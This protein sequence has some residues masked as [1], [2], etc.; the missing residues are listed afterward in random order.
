MNNV[1]TWMARDP[2][3]TTREEL[4]RLIDSNDQLALEERFSA[5]L[6]FGTAGLRGI[7]GAGPNRMNRLVIQETALGLGTY[8]LQQVDDAAAKGVVIGY[9][10][11]PDSKQFATDA[12]V[13]LGS[14]GIH[15]YLTETVAP[16]PVVAFS[17][18]HL[19]AA[20]GVVVTA[21]HNPPAYNGFKVYWGNGAQ[22]IPPH[23]SGIAAQID[24]AAQAPLPDLSLSQIEPLG[25]LS[26]LGGAFYA[27]YRHAV[28]SSPFLSNHTAPEKVSIAYTAMH[29]VGADLAETL[30]ADAGFNQVYSVKAQREP[31]GTFPT[32]NFPNPEE[33]GAMD[34]VIAEAKAHGATLACANDPDA[35]RFAVAVRTEEGEYKMLTG[36]QVGM[37]LGH[38]LLTRVTPNEALVGTTIVSS[39]LLEKIAKSVDAK[40]FQT[41]TGFKWLTNVAMEKE[42]P[43]Q[44]FVFAYEE[45][46]GYT[47]GTTVWDKDGLSALVAFAQLTAELAA[48]GATVWDRI[49]AIYREH[50][51]YLNAQRSIALQPGSP[52]IGDTLRAQPPSTIAGRAV[53]RTD[54]L[55]TSQRIDAEGVIETIDLPASDVLIYH[56]DDASRVVVRPS[57]TE[58]K[59]KCYYEVV[60]AMG[61]EDCLKH[62]QQRAEEAMADLIEKHQAS[63]QG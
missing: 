13:M 32:V 44:P 30:L 25:L 7:V 48:N 35:D 41:L 4:Q 42:T 2:D 15:V 60:E 1:S 5:R 45:A 9:D 11:R 24:I 22:I 50:G 14:L 58:P 39:S 29:G 23:D 33:P 61:H 52:P 21:S 17:V 16:T 6:A 20:A 19:N 59:L 43:E 54:D 49:E 63:L 40:Y 38:Y 57:G 46:L 51:L 53:V 37:L 8:L 18:R 36:D 62:V 3:P 56:L 26:L 31:D 27:Q 55:K 47:V 34:M 12:A 28:N 10:G